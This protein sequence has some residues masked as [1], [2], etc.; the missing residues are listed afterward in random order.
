VLAIAKAV[1]LCRVDAIHFCRFFPRFEQVQAVTLNLMDAYHQS[2]LSPR[3]GLALDQCLDRCRFFSTIATCRG[4][5][6]L[7]RHRGDGA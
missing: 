5:K 1:L 6:S 2:D 3:Q 7:K 4:W